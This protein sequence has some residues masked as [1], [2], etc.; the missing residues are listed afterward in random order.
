[1]AFRT[2]PFETRAGSA[3]YLWEKWN[4]STAFRKGRNSLRDDV[5]LLDIGKGVDVILFEDHV[6]AD[7]LDGDVLGVLILGVAGN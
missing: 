1:M 6:D 7:I 4:D 5:Q 3:L 2:T